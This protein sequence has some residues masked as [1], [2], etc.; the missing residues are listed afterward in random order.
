MSDESVCDD[1]YRDKS[2]FSWRSQNKDVDSWVSDS[3]AKYRSIYSDFDK[4]PKRNTTLVN[5]LSNLRVSFENE[6]TPDFE[7]F[8][9]RQT[10]IRESRKN[11]EKSTSDTSTIERERSNERQ[12]RE[13]YG[14]DDY[15]GSP[16]RSDR[17]HSSPYMTSTHLPKLKLKSFDGNAL[18]WP[19]WSSMFLATVH[20]QR[21]PES[22]KMSHLKTLLTGDAKA[23]ISGMG[24]SGRFYDAAWRVLQ[25][26][27]GRPHLIADAQLQAVKKAP[28]VQKNDSKTL[29]QFSV[30]T[31]GDF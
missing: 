14:F 7:N 8:P 16:T 10:T 12:M 21:I 11:A 30:V 17:R 29:I 18:D 28:F 4:S 20:S 27:F 22:E 3:K 23:S 26:N 5:E 15:D 31:D 6:Q 1:K 19:E 9:K 24:Y 25:K 2:P 13:S